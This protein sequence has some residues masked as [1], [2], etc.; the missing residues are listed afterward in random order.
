MKTSSHFLYALLTLITISFL[1]PCTVMANQSTP[2]FASLKK[3]NDR[4]SQPVYG[5]SSVDKRRIQGALGFSP[6]EI[7]ETGRWLFLT[8]V[9]LFVVFI[10][11]KLKTVTTLM[12]E[13]QRKP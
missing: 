4:S 3:S 10:L 13:E 1:M 5:S 11:V 9:S 2:R 8:S 6:Q 7:E 12:K